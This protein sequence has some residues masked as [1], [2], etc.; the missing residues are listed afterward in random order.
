MLQPTTDQAG[1]TAPRPLPQGCTPAAG[2]GERPGLGCLPP[3]SRGLRDDPFRRLRQRRLLT[4]CLPLPCLSGRHFK[5][6]V[7]FLRTFFH[8]FQAW[9]NRCRQ[10]NGKCGISHPRWLRGRTASCGGRLCKALWRC[11]L[12]RGGVVFVLVAA[13]GPR[14][15]TTATAA[16]TGGGPGGG[17]CNDDGVSGGGRALTRFLPPRPPSCCTW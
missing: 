4:A 15:W 11:G 1:D 17:C 7:L 6:V 8:S 13:L 9:L 16:S 10:M 5:I 2:H 12:G 14:V 3:H